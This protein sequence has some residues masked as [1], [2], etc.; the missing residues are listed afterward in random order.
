MREA[1]KW[2]DDCRPIKE[3]VPK[4]GAI[5]AVGDNAIGHGRR[6]TDR[7]GDDRHAEEDAIDQVADKSRLARATLYTTL[8]PCTPHVRRN[9]LKCCT[10]LIR[11]HQIKKVFIGIRVCT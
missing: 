7:S 2:A 3:S 11:Q 4:V 6:G 10:E 5:I 9:P 1:I 8:E